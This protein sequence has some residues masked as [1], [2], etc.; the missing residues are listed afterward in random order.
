MAEVVLD[1]F[2]A[3][4]Q[5]RG[6]FAP[7]HAFGEC[8]RYLKLLGRQLLA[9]AVNADMSRLAACLKLLSRTSSPRFSAELIKGLQRKPEVLSRIEAPAAAPQALPKIKLRPRPLKHVGRGVVI[10][11]RS[12]EFLNKGVI[13]SHQAQCPRSSS[14]RER[15]TLALRRQD[16]SGG[17][18]F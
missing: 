1:G 17:A 12:L 13:A 16:W 8:E 11:E 10:T 6:R 14:E 3:Q 2:R 15:Q 7:G 5:S 4:V 18:G 9:A